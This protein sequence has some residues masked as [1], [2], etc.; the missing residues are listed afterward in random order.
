MYLIVT[1]YPISFLSKSEVAK[2]PIFGRITTNVQSIYIERKVESQ[3]EK[4]VEDIKERVNKF[5]E[6]AKEEL[7][8]KVYPLIIFPEGTTSNGRS[9]LKFKVGAFNDLAPLTIIGLK[10]TCNLYQIFRRK[11]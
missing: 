3:R 4:I 10:Y 8:E 1:F 6:K 9:L 11:F 7:Y 5:M 2:V